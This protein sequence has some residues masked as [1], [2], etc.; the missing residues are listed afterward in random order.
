MNIEQVFFEL[1]QVAIGTRKALTV[2]PTSREWALLFEMAKKQ[3]LTAVAFAGVNRLKESCIIKGSGPLMS[4][5]S[6]AGGAV[7]AS[8]LMK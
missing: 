2:K 4:Q 7:A 3:A 6:S 8:E 5:V 1:M